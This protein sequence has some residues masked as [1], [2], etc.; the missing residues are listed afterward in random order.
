[1]RDYRWSNNS[2]TLCGASQTRVGIIKPHRL[3][4]TNSFKVSVS[5]PYVKRKARWSEAIQ[6]DGESPCR[7]SNLAVLNDRQTH[8]DQ[9]CDMRQHW[10]VHVVEAGAQGCEPARSVSVVSFG[11]YQ[12]DLATGSDTKVPL[13]RLVRMDFSFSDVVACL[14]GVE[15]IF[16]ILDRERDPLHPCIA[17]VTADDGRR[18]VAF[19][20][21]SELCA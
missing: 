5:R 2:Y 11:A 4:F 15:N 16:R 1:M 9:H 21:F 13:T 10:V 19:R 14:I 3:L 6:K 20:S 8:D 18:A 7:A 12:Y 17:F